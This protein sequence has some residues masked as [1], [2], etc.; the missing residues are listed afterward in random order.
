MTSLGFNSQLISRRYLNTVWI[1]GAVGELESETLGADTAPPPSLDRRRTVVSIV[2][3]STS[4]TVELRTCVETSE[5]RLDG[6]SESVALQW[7]ARVHTFWRG[8]RSGCQQ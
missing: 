5:A 7:A 4:A 2:L 3:F 8:P 1:E 6:V